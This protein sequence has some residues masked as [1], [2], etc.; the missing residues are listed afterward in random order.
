MLG[1]GRLSIKR[2]R[3]V[4]TPIDRMIVQASG[5]KHPRAL[6]I[7]TASGD[8]E[9]Y[10]AVFTEV[11]TSLGATVEVLRLWGETPSRKQIAAAV[12][13]ADLI[14]VGGGNTL[15]MLKWWKKHGVDRELHKAHKRGV[16]LCGLSAGAICWCAY[17]NSDSWKYSNPKA[18]YIRIKALGVVPVLLCPHADTE[19]GRRASLKSI[20]RRTPGAGVAVDELCAFW[21]DGNRWKVVSLAKKAQVRRCLWRKGKYIDEPLPADGTLRP[22]T[23]LTQ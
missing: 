5:K 22:L 18:P 15:R 1:G 21:V 19:K 9:R 17:G 2:K 6:F 12:S 7:P 16:V 23:A 20:M 8:S 13:R 4:T 10:I 11:Y 3:A 14:Y